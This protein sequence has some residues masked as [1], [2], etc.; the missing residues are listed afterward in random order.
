[1]KIRIKNQLEDYFVFKQN[2]LHKDDDFYIYK[3]L[4]YEEI[5]V[6]PII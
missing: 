5:L 6:I 3:P 1:M 4:I 2:I